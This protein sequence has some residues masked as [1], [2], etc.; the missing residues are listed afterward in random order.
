M[1]Y[2]WSV[3]DGKFGCLVCGLV[4][5]VWCVVNGVVLLRGVFFIIYEKCMCWVLLLE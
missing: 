2:G 1:K 3:I 4:F 5:E